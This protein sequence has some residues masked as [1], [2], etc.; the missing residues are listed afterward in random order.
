MD[1][2]IARAGRKISPNLQRHELPGHLDLGLSASGLNRYRSGRAGRLL[3]TRRRPMAV[4]NAGLEE[5]A[6]L[7]DALDVLRPRIAAVLARL[8]VLGALRRASALIFCSGGYAR[9]D[10][11]ERYGQRDQLPDA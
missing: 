5:V 4:A 6:T 7:L 2:K 1:S 8:P 10:D 11:D 9:E 3:G